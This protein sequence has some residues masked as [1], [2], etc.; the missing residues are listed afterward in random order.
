MLFITILKTQESKNLKQN[1]FSEKIFNLN[2]K[3]LEKHFLFL[4]FYDRIKPNILIY[5]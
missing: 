3:C 2:W 4:K 5:F 1:T